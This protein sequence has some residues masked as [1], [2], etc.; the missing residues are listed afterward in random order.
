MQCSYEEWFYSLFPRPSPSRRVLCALGLRQSLSL[1]PSS[2][3]EQCQT[4]KPKHAVAAMGNN[5]N[6]WLLP[7]WLTLLNNTA[8]VLPLLRWGAHSL[9]KRRTGWIGLRGRAPHALHDNPTETSEQERPMGHIIHP[10]LVTRF[11][12]ALGACLSRALQA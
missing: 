4:Q 12:P 11:K 1:S 10:L 8:V 2:S 9:N 6:K 3:S 7:L 5:V